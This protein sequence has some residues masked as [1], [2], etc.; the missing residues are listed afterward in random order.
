MG[1]SAVIAA[2]TAVSAYS[3]NK[4]NQTAK[5]GMR[6][7]SDQFDQQSAMETTRM[8]GDMK[9]AQ[10]NIAVQRGAL[11]QQW[12][13]LGAQKEASAKAQ[14]LAETNARDADIANNKAARK[15]PNVGAML[16]GNDKAGQ[17]GGASTLLTGA[18]GVGS[19]SLGK[20]SALGG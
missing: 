6:Q 3:A 4:A 20:T 16:T 8:Q 5:A 11:N 13:A 10:A 9:N 18:G 19:G 17:S 1:I 15:S 2:S 12:A 14:A 7:A